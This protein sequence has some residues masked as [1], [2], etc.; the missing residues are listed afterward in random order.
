EGGDLIASVK[1]A[2]RP[3]IVMLHWGHTGSLLPSPEQRRLAARLVD[4]GATAVLGHGPHTLQGVERRARA[5]IAYSL[6]NLAFSCPCTDA[7]DAYLLKFRIADDFG[8][9]DLA[10]LPISAGIQGQPPRRSSDPGLQQLL[11]ELSRDLA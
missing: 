6:G 2:Q 9:E 5:V 1:R 8:A 7:R 4:A 3:V 11:D 10:V